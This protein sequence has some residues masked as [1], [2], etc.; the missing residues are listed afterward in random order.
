[1]A[2]PTD[3]TN[4]SSAV[5]HVTATQG[6]ALH[7]NIYSRAVLR[8]D[9]VISL[10]G[11]ESDSP[12][13]ILFSMLDAAD[14]PTF[15]FSH[16]RD[17][18]FPS[19]VIAT[20]AATNSA[21]SIVVDDWKYIVAQMMLHVPSTGEWMRVTATPSTSTVAV[22]RGIG[23][24]TGTAI[25][26]GATII[27]GPIAVPE[28]SGPVDTFSTEPWKE[29]NYIETRRRGTKV[30]RHA[31]LEEKWGGTNKLDYELQKN[32]V[33]LRRE[34]E[35]SY[36]LGV[37]AK[38][39]DSAGSLLYLS[40][41]V[42]DIAKASDSRSLHVDFDGVVVT[43]SA[44]DYQVRR[45]YQQKNGGGRVIMLCG[46]GMMDT[47]TKWVDDKLVIDNPMADTFGTAVYRYQ[48]SNGEVLTCLP[49]RLWTNEWDMDDR[50]WLLDMSKLRVRYIR[51]DG[52][53]GGTP[54]IQLVTR[55]QDTSE[56]DLAAIGYDYFWREFVCE[57][58]LQ[59]MG[60]ENIAIFEGV[61]S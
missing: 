46:N 42:E 34:I 22:T 7:T 30:S 38:T 32:L 31:L 24:T 56:V 14:S 1:M 57:T 50:V 12:Y 16:Y 9:E 36:L 6:T 11:D 37:K 60:T 59:V 40:G 43:R 55:G 47:L 45:Y 21:T 52:R 18:N 4:P 27:L 29:T 35:T 54:N 15:E 49:H 44:F 25:A 2:A 8:P 58:G 28:G 10:T 23:S 17:E 19:K 41:G 5:D 20:A 13:Y 33:R 53:F 26:S 61:R 3:Y 39:T 51:G 48:C